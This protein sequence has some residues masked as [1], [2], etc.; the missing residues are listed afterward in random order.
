MAAAICS[1]RKQGNIGAVNEFWA[2][3]TQADGTP[4]ADG[5]DALTFIYYVENPFGVD[6]VITEAILNVIALD[7][8]DITLDI[9]LSDDAAGT[10]VG[11]ELFDHAANTAVAVLRGL[12]AQG[13][14]GVSAPIWRKSGYATD[15]FITFYQTDLDASAL[16]RF[17]LLVKCVP[18][19]Q[20]S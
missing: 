15:S 1:F 12:P 2:K 16:C 9:G 17:V 18:L 8:T 6:V 20:M 3:I 7:A 5:T 4:L 14:I 19:E 10:G 13:I 11:K